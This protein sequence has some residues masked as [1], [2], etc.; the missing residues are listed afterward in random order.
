MA[1]TMICESKVPKTLWAE[2]L[3]TTC[4]ISNSVLIRPKFDKTP[5]ELLRGRKTNISYFHPFG[6]VCYVLRP[7]KD[8]LGKFDAKSDEGIFLA[9]STTS[10]AYRAL[11]KKTSKIEGSINVKID[12]SF[13][14]TKDTVEPVVSLEPA[15]TDEHTSSPNFSNGFEGFSVD[16]SKEASTSNM[17]N[18]YS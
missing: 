1:R 12:D 15:D 11:N 17:D 7:S 8:N 5:Y 9:Y 13:N 16:P 2:A 10:K 6:S 18:Q 3:N 4:Y 14:K